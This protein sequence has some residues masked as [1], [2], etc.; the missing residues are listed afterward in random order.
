MGVTKREGRHWPRWLLASVV[1][2]ASIAC[3]DSTEPTP[4][5]GFWSANDVW[6][7]QIFITPDADAPRWPSD[8]V[9]S[10]KRAPTASL[11]PCTTSV[12]DDPMFPEYS[13]TYVHG[14][15]LA[16]MSVLT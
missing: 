8:P 16:A 13:V 1:M 6:S 5:N 15:S 7:G 3:S 14:C 9:T 2:A 11:G 12:I 10:L 4:P